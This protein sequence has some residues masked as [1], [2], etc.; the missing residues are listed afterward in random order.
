MGSGI[1]AFGTAKLQPCP[2][3]DYLSPFVFDSRVHGRTVSGMPDILAFSVAF[4]R[5]E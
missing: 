4:A 3:L 5:L 1:A 2:E